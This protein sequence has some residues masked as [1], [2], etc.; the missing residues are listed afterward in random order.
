MS[1]DE[2][3]IG[4]CVV[5]ST[6]GI[7]RITDVEEKIFDRDKRNYFVLVP[8]FDERSTYYIP[9]DYDSEKVH[10]K[11]SLTES[12][13]LDLCEYVKT[14]RPLEWI[15]NPNERKQSFDKIYKSGTRKEKVH[16][17]KAI[18]NHE[19]KQKAL[20]KQLY[21][22]DERFLRGCIGV[23]AD[24]LAFVLGRDRDELRLELDF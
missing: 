22:T 11:P 13:A 5:Y 2:L 20:G 6:K 23:L 14:A 18:K 17:I 16:L 3:K 21:A 1:H 8:I 12:E 7:C 10:I 9:Q 4:D 24:E 19:A 15:T